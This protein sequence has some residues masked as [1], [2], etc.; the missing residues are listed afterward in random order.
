MVPSSDDFQTRN[1]DGTQ[2][3]LAM[4]IGD[5]NVGAVEMGVGIQPDAQEP[6]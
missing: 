5:C 4:L 6:A 3:G 1:P 2:P